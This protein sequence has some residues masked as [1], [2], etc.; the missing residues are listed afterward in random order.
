[1]KNAF[2]STSFA[3]TLALAAFAWA[4]AASAQQMFKTPEAAAEA[5]INAAKSNDET[6]ALAVLGA[7][8]DDIVSSGDKVA[9]AAGRAN[10]AAAYDAKHQIAMEG[11]NKAALVIGDKDFPFPIPLVRGKNGE[12]SFDVASGRAEILFRRIGRNELS[13][14][15]TILAVVDAEQEY[16]SKDHGQGVGAYA[17]HFFSSEGKQD[18]LFWPTKEGEEPSPLGALAATASSEGYTHG[19]GPAPYHG[20]YYKILTRQGTAAPGGAADYVV[21]GK[22]IGGFA[23][24][25][26][27]AE[28][29]NSG[30]MTFIVNYNGQVYEKDL[31]FN[32]PWV[33]GGMTVYNPDPS[34]SKVDTSKAAD[35]VS[36]Q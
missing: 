15:E 33:A 3:A 23:V 31:G 18:G 5:L 30:V 29:R 12:W 8:A 21:K 20:Y 36:S 35:W 26:Y 10:F 24:V 25:A 27:P 16:A 6:A 34:W 22:M 11:Q 7:N 2:L 17:Q 32:T 28:Y 19:D 9:D 4:D 1:M 13:A 14:I